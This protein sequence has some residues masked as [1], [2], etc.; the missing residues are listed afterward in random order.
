MGR[1]RRRKGSSSR[2]GGGR[3]RR[4][5]RRRRSQRGRSRTVA[6]ASEDLARIANK[7]KRKIFG[8]SSKSA[9]G[10]MKPGKEAAVLGDTIT[11]LVSDPRTVGTINKLTEGSLG[12][13]ESVGKVGVDTAKEAVL[14]EGPVVGEGLET[15]VFAGQD[16]GA[17][18]LAGVV[19][20]VPEAGD[21][22]AELIESGTQ[23]SQVAAG[24]I[25]DAVQGAVAGT[26]VAEKFGHLLGDS[27]GSFVGLGEKVVK[28]KSNL[29]NIAHDAFEKARF[30]S[31]DSGLPGYGGSRRRR[32]RTKR[33][34][35]RKR[36][37]T[38][39]RRRAR[40]RRSRRRRR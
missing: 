25:G 28:A 31:G 36:R 10:S 11:N 2:G 32:R 8:A 33:R 39:K 15:A 29:D 35:R 9:L 17:D 37:R 30:D 19:G 5:R 4:R 14:K 27:A 20:V 34:K 38:R 1:A 23:A 21:V 7:Y 13:L 6:L 22:G 26:K 3:R 40:R 24:A 12:A 16:V 18:A